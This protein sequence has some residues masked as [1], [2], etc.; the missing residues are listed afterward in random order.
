MIKTR[1]E[2][3]KNKQTNKKLATWIGEMAQWANYGAKLLCK[4]EDLSMDPQTPH[5]SWAWWPNP[6]GLRGSNW[7]V[8]Y[9]FRERPYPTKIKWRAI[10]SGLQ[11][12]MHGRVH[13]HTHLLQAHICNTHTPNTHTQIKIKKQKEAT[14]PKMVRLSSSP[15]IEVMHVSLLEYHTQTMAIINDLL[16]SPSDA[17]LNLRK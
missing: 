12:W 5:E 4:H 6:S 17:L 7:K 3:K 16:H 14:Q 15:L 1:W 13:P 11:T 8:S 10:N 9:R 2:F